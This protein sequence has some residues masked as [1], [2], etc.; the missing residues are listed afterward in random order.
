MF[1]GNFVV[2]IIVYHK[3]FVYSINVVEFKFCYMYVFYIEQCF[4]SSSLLSRMCYLSYYPTRE[5][6]LTALLD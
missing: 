1:R 2:S 6:F 5:S 3:V 4:F